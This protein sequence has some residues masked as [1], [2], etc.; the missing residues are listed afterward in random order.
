MGTKQALVVGAK[1]FMTADIEMVF[2][3]D[4]NDLA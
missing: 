3:A 1:T 4:R 2:E